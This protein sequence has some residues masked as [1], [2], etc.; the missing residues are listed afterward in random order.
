MVVS[1]SR[2]LALYDRWGGDNYDEDISQL[3]HAEQTAALAV[4]AGAPAPL[5]AASLLHDIGH[6]LQLAA[7]PDRPLVRR[8]EQAG[9]AYLAPLFPAEVT[10]PIGLH[11]EAKRYLC[12]A[13]AG[14][15]D[16][17]SNG[18]KRSL[19]RQGGPMTPGQTAA[20]EQRPGA[21]DALLL[22]RWDDRGKVEGL[23]VTPIAEYEAMLQDLAR[24]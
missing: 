21:E 16:R 9:V 18:S 24:P 17:L 1:V 8:H 20:F 4:R 11:V 13:D 22:R 19:T 7:P 14:Y 12:A 3:A 5:V 10:D 6:L 2:V 15:Y 23:P